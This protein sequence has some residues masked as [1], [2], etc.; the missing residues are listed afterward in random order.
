M[1]VLWEL[2]GSLK[3]KAISAACRV[4]SQPTERAI[5]FTQSSHT[6]DSNRASLF[7]GHLLFGFPGLGSTPWPARCVPVGRG[8]FSN[9]WTKLGPPGGDL[10][11]NRV[12]SNRS[13]CF[14]ETEFCA[15]RQRG[16]IERSS[17]K[18]AAETKLRRVCVALQEIVVRVQYPCTGAPN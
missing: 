1:A 10:H 4:L 3:W 9:L 8:A 17:Q 5:R 16:K 18:A 12:S 15:Q 14:R 7:V 2:H 11:S 13:L 6:H